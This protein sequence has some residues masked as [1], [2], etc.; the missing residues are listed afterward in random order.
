MLYHT[1][2]S[3]KYQD[4]LLYRCFFLTICFM[5]FGASIKKYKLLHCFDDFWHFKW[6]IT[7][8]I[9]WQTHHKVH[10][11]AVVELTIISHNLPQSSS[12]FLNYRCSNF[13][14]SEHY[15]GFWYRLAYKIHYFNYFLF[16]SVFFSTSSLIFCVSL[17]I[18]VWH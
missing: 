15:K 18:A 2:I 10:L 12:T 9:R 8:C 7:V 4:C 11:V 1:Q 17:R 3:A 6:K 14:F 16:V 5:W 13:Y